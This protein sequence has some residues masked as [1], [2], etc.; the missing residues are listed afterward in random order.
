MRC[1]HHLLGFWLFQHVPLIKPSP[2]KEN[3]LFSGLTAE[4]YWTESQPLIGYLYLDSGNR[5]TESQ[6][7]PLIRFRNVVDGNRPR[8]WV[9]CVLFLRLRGFML[10]SSLPQMWS[11]ELSELSTIVSF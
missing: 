2:L 6:S 3:S 10:V 7:S 5:Y 1:A 8:N 9:R 4:L 11:H